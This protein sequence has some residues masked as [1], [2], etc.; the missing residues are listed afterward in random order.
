MPVVTN[1]LVGWVAGT[2]VAA[3]E[4][5]RISGGS[6]RNADEDQDA[7]DHPANRTARQQPIQEQPKQKRREEEQWQSHDDARRSGVAHACSNRFHGFSREM[8]GWRRGV[9]LECKP[10]VILQH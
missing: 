3:R 2:G 5:L 6:E 10:S 9:A 8:L 7:G 4:K 1:A